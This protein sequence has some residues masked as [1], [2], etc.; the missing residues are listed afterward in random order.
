MPDS[1]AWLLPPA[2]AGVGTLSTLASADSLAAQSAPPGVLGSL[3]VFPPDPAN[4]VSSN[5]FPIPM[6]GSLPGSATGLLVDCGSGMSV[7]QLAAGK[8][9]LLQRASSYYCRCAATARC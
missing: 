5:P 4:V 2:P 6:E 8:V 3:V 1:H 9:C 7:C